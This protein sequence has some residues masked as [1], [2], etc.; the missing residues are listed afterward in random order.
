MKKT[1]LFIVIV[2]ITSS[3]FAQEKEK[4]E[5]IKALKIAFITQKLQLN[6]T[7]AE[8]FWPIYNAFETENHMLRKLSIDKR[9]QL[10]LDTMT[11]AGANKS[12]KDLMVFETKKTNLKS[13]FIE[14]LLKV[15]PAKKIILLKIS[16]DEFNKRMFE[17]YRK[18]RKK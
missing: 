17:E 12:L 14:N 3:I 15:I 11:E 5:R 1:A 8:K 13:E 9:K 10:D 4:R 7:E 2:L 16:E 6:E 18:R